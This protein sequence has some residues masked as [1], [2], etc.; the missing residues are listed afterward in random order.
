MYKSTGFIPHIVLIAVLAIHPWTAVAQEPVEPTGEGEGTATGSQA[1]EMTVPP[2]VSGAPCFTSEDCP[3]GEVCQDGFCLGQC[4]DRNMES[5]R[6]DYD[7]S[8]VNAYQQSLLDQIAPCLEAWREDRIR[9]EGHTDARGS[10]AYNLQVSQRMAQSVADYLATLGVDPA[11][12][13]VVGFG[14]DRPICSDP[15]E[16]CR[17]K[18]RRVELV[19]IP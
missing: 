2:V 10:A 15:T 4:P 17:S 1:V 18:N 16:E 3:L 7:S 11:R 13:E 5:I 9:L 19:W 12:M 6:F 14:E 8:S